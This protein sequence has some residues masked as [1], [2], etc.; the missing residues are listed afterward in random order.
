MLLPEARWFGEKIASLKS[1][2]IF[3]MFNI[4]SSTEQ[5]R[6]V[7]QPWIDEFIFE[8]LAGKAV[9]HVDIKEAAGVDV[10]GDLSKLSFQRELLNKHPK[11]VMCLNLLEHVI[12]RDDMSKKIISLVPIGGYIFVS[13]PYKFPYHADPIDTLFRPSPDELAKLFPGTKSIY[14]DVI[15]GEN[16]LSML[17]RNKLKA[18]KT[19][20]RMLFPF[21]NPH[22]WYKQA[23]YFPWLF[24]NF[25]AT[26]LVLRKYE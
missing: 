20:F 1:E 12:N 15:V 9:F 11:S 18:C 25:K 22:N 8:P 13:C 16:Y 2:D 17:S 14:S 23:V 10:V 5:F 3:P 24:K 4:G 6:K 21:Y 26:C 7:D 19:L